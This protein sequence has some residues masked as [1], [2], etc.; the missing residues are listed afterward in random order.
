MEAEKATNAVTTGKN[1]PKRTVKVTKGDVAEFDRGAYYYLD[2]QLKGQAL[3]LNMIA[4]ARSPA[5]VSGKSATV[6][7]FFNRDEA[8]KRSLQIGDY[9]SLNEHPDL[10]LFEGYRVKGKDGG[11]TIRQR[12]N[13]GTSFLE[14]E[15]RKG[16][17][18]DVGVEIEKTGAQ[19]FLS[20]FVK[21]LYMG[22]FLVVLIGGVAIVIAITLLID[23]C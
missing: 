23:K 14:E 9:E 22:G 20:G 6:F 19:K 11:L 1:S 16:A 4:Q 17:I 2:K 10:I 21:F 12:E 13:T 5:K 3:R 8:T 7:R 15:I 18:T